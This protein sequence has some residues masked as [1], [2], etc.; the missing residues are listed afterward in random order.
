MDLL[1]IGESIAKL[2]LPIIGAMLPIPGASAICSALASQ[3]GAPSPAPADILA[4]LTQNADALEKAKQF[5]ETHAETML[6][7][8]IEQEQN[9]MANAAAIAAT[10]EADTASARERET[11]SGDVW[12]PRL[13]AL[14]VLVMYGYVQYFALTHVIPAESRDLATRGMGILDMAVGLVLGYYFGSSVHT[15][16]TTELLASKK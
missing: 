11:K 9:E 5:E 13:I 3:I 2:G 4:T 15:A 12:T 16:R 1:Q 7:L 8:Q 6:K 14:V 10:N